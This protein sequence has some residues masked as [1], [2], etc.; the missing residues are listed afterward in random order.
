[1]KERK[2]KKML[3]HRSCLILMWL[4]KKKTFFEK[5]PETHEKKTE[6]IT[7]YVSTTTD[8]TKYFCYYSLL[9]VD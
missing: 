6:N 8:P 7:L 5:M 3:L 1:M 2:K 9:F 4:E